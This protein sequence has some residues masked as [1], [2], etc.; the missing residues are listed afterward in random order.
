MW[1]DV[2]TQTEATFPSLPVYNITAT[3]AREI[4][5][6]ICHSEFFSNLCDYYTVTEQANKFFTVVL[7]MSLH[8]FT[9]R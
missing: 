6:Q 4:K 1:Q 3:S 9:S 5:T 7:F 2:E 8:M